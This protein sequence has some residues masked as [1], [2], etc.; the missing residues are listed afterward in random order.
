MNPIIEKSLT[1][2]PNELL[3][4]VCSCPCE[5]CQEVDKLLQGQDPLSIPESLGSNIFL[6][7]REALLYFIPGLMKLSLTK[8]SDCS[9]S[10]LDILSEPISKKNPPEFHKTLGELTYEQTA[11]IVSFLEEM[12]SPDIESKKIYRALKNWKHFLANFNGFASSDI[13]NLH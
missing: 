9:S 8:D 12:H 2:F 1:F 13:S 10:F 7:S 6:L 11:I 4:Y 5:D 3:S